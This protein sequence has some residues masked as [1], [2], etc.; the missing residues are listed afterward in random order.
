M[1]NQ[2]NYSVDG[3]NKKGHINSNNG[4]KVQKKDN[5]KKIVDTLKSCVSIEYCS[6]GENIKNQ[7]ISQ[8]ELLDLNKDRFSKGSEGS[9]YKITI[10]N[11]DGSRKEYL[12]AK[13][14]YDNN[15]S[16]ER[17]IHKRI[18][19]TLKYDKENTNNVGVPELKAVFN[20]NGDNFII[21][22]FIKGKTLYQLEIEKILEKRGIHIGTINNDIESENIFFRMFDL[23]PLNQEDRK[24][25]S[26]LYY[27]ELNNIKLFEPE[28]GKEYIKNLDDFLKK[29][30]NEGLYHRDLSNPRNIILGDNKKIYIIDF[31]KSIDIKHAKLTDKQIY[32]KQEGELVGIHPKDE[33]ILLKIKTLTK[34]EEDIKLEKINKEIKEK[35]KMIEKGK[36]IYSLIN[37]PESWIKGGKNREDIL[38]KAKNISTNSKR[39]SLSDIMGTKTNKEKIALLFAQSY[40]NIDY[41]LEQVIN[42]SARLQNMKQLEKTKKDQI[43]SYTLRLGDEAIKRHQEIFLKKIKKIENQITLIEDIEN[44]LLEIKHLIKNSV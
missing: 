1:D 19:E 28:Q 7:I 4:I 14:R 35:V 3:F 31:G 16:N 29:I 25:A 27:N 44:K 26:K 5:I 21:M 42:E 33:E 11:D 32:E 41:L 37:I 17:H 18:L 30:H 22:E 8:L 24:R 40:E 38:K 43:P 23:D 39:I 20:L 6:V 36:T 15:P 34:T 13:K 12:V 2:G 9:V 10:K